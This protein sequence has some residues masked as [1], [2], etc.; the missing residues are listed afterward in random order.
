MLLATLGWR[1]FF[2]ALGIASMVWLGPWLVWG[3]KAETAKVE[4]RE[5]GPGIAEILECRSA[6]GAFLGHFFANYFWFFL[7][8]WLPTYLV[9][10]RGLSTE[11]MASVSSIVYLTVAASTVAAGWFSDRWIARGASPTQVRK[12]VVSGGLLFATVIFPVAL[13]ESAALAI[14]LLLASA[15]GFGVYAS[16]H[17]AITQTLSGPL[18]AGRW[19]SLQNGVGNLAGVAAAWFTGFAVQHTHSFA[20]AFFASAAAAMLGAAMWGLVVGPV[21]AVEWRATA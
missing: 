21:R 17:W 10:E 7:L 3:P 11:R 15:V 13:V 1:A 8:T 5:R 9:K 6:W 12:S 2:V 20:A 16:N 18:A 14:A 19:T 4:R